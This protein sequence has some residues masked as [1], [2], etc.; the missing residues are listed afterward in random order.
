MDNGIMSLNQQFKNSGFYLSAERFSNVFEYLEKVDKTRENI[1][2]IVEEQHHF[3]SNLCLPNVDYGAL[4]ETGNNLVIQMNKNEKALSDLYNE[5]NL[6]V[7]ML[8]LYVNFY[9]SVRLDY[10]FKKL[11]DL[12]EKWL[13]TKSSQKAEDTFTE[14]KRKLKT[15][16]FYKEGNAII[17]VNIMKNQFFISKFTSNVPEMFEYS[18]EE[19]N[20]RRV[21]DLLPQITSIIHD[22]VLLNFVN[23]KNNSIMQTGTLTSF[24]VTKSVKP[25]MVSA[26]VK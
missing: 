7:R 17:Y 2:Q 6:V 13:S 26:L 12:I 11:Q 23:Q 24:A 18:I 3:Y 25:R 16:N 10:D 9:Q 5:N 14:L 4:F 1:K 8:V 20:G 19:I 21:N 15:V 22:N